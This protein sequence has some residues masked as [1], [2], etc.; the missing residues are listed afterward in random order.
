MSSTRTDKAVGRKME[1]N[2]DAERWKRR[3]KEGAENEE[4]NEQKDEQK[5]HKG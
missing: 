4:A 2:N 5:H 1:A 3:T